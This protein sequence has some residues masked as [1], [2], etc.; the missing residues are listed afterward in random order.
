MNKFTIE[1]AII[2]RFAGAVGRLC[3]MLARAGLWL[4][5]RTRR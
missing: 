3:L 1:D 4:K 2:Y 5:S